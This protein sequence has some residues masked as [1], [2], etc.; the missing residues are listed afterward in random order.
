[1]LQMSTAQ[2]LAKSQLPGCC[3]QGWS[4][5]NTA[6][7][8]LWQLCINLLALSCVETPG[9][10]GEGAGDHELESCFLLVALEL[11][12]PVWTLPHQVSCR[13]LLGY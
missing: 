9:H 7:S 1:M 4:L 12:G 13:G 8:I 6:L 3:P 2:M 11:A 10:L 5:S